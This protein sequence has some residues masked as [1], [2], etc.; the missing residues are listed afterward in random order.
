MAPHRGDRHE[1]RRS[2]DA[3]CAD[4]GQGKQSSE[5]KGRSSVVAA[6]IRFHVYKAIVHF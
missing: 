5:L 1:H 2:R 6:V 4:A 3:Y